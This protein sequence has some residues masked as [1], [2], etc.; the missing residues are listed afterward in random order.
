VILTGDTEQPG[1][2]EAG[3]MFRLIAAE[4]GHW[5]LAEVRRF[6]EAWERE[7][8][9]KLR[10]GDL[11]AWGERGYGTHGRV[12][13][14]PQ[15][16][17]Y[18]D[19]VDFWLTDYARGKD[20]LLLAGSNEEA[21][22]L[23]GMV[24]A[25]RIE[26]GEIPGVREVTLPDG[27]AAGTGDLVRARLNT[28][29]DA[30]GRPLA[31]RDTLRIEGWRGPGGGRGTAAHRGRGGGGSAHGR[32]RRRAAPGPRGAGRAGTAKRG[33]VGPVCRLAKAYRGEKLRI[34]LDNYGTHKYPD[35]R[36]RDAVLHPLGCDEPG[37][38]YL[39]PI[40]SET[41]RATLR[42]ST[43]HLIASSAFSLRSRASSARSSSLS[44]PPQPSRRR[45][46]RSTQLPSV[47]ELIPRFRATCAIGL[48]V[49]RT[50]RTAPSRKSGSNFLRV[51][52]I[53]PPFRRCLHATRGNPGHDLTDA[54]DGG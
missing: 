26:R 34:M 1:P 49:S 11:A 10:A 42:L 24:R 27:N 23:A 31:N 46:S 39:L 9:L 19:A 20:T 40:T 21:A 7:A 50:S 41:R 53:A 13:E 30:G 47:P 6:N 14:G 33:V 4:A 28:Q 38:G 52:A 45:R 37:H 29:I 48:P 3:G 12:Y 2:V 36:V 44:A 15:D 51:S 17:V 16:L 18:D 22:K 25:R 32:T 8:S 54:K 35:V 5:K 43:S